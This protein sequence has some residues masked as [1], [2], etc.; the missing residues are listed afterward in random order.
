M[1]TLFPTKPRIANDN[2]DGARIV[3]LS[4]RREAAARRLALMSDWAPAI[5]ATFFVDPRLRPPARP[6]GSK[7]N[8][9]R[10]RDDSSP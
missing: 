9:K 8:R 1:K 10:D 6:S 4:E 5:L 7:A 3:S 2:G